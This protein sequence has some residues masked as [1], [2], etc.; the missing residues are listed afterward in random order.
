MNRF[1]FKFKFV[2]IIPYKLRGNYYFLS[3]L[4]VISLNFIFFGNEHL[5]WCRIMNIVQ[6]LVKSY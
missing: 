2:Y 6:Y 1:G 4:P 5:Q 3:G